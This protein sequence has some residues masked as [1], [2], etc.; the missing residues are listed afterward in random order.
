MAWQ[1]TFPVSM[2]DCKQVNALL[3][4]PQHKSIA[5]TGDDLQF[6]LDDSPILRAGQKEIIDAAPLQLLEPVRL[7]HGVAPRPACEGGS[8]AIV[9]EGNSGLFVALA[10]RGR[11]SRAEREPP[12]SVAEKGSRNRASVGTERIACTSA[13]DGTDATGSENE[14]FPRRRKGSDEA[15]PKRFKKRVEKEATGFVQ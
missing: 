2:P 12:Y 10:R 5:M 6:R 9:R 13:F 4:E 14:G 3:L 7:V 8:T 1:N 15:E 11:C